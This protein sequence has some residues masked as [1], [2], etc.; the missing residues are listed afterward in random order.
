MITA[1]PAITVVT[2]TLNAEQYLA[3]CLASVRAAANE[4]EVEH[5]VVDGG[6]TDQTELIARSANVTWVSLPG[7]R[8]AAAINEGF[9]RARGD[10]LAWLNADDL[11]VPGALDVVARTFRAAPDLEVLVGDCDVIGP[12]GEHLWWER[13]GP[14]DRARLL[15]RGNY[16]AQP[17]VFLRRSVLEAVGYLDESLEYAMDFDL[18]V[19]LGGRHVTYEP[20]VLSRFR[21]HPASKSA[22][23]QRAGWAENLRILRKH[24][25]GWSPELAWAYARCLLTTGRQRAGR[26]VRSH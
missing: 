26:L 15:R 21:W 7:S 14:F 4:T 11:Y 20:R 19:R 5:I 18:W 24:G 17:A 25:H 13:Q 23:G 3:G 9:R 10:V 16:I 1:V 8:Q 6:S 12:A 2:P 22:R